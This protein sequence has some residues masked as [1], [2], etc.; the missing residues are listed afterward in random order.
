MGRS[1]T[2]VEVP[3]VV[4]GAAVAAGAAGLGLKHLRDRA[5]GNRG[6]SS[7][8]RLL[9]GEPVADGVKRVILGR[10]DDAVEQLSGGAPEPAEGVHEARKDLK[11]IRSALR[12]VRAELGDDVWRRENEHYR[13][14]GRALSGFRDAEVMVETLDTLGDRYGD[15]ARERFSGL[16]AELEQ[17][18]H[19]QRDDGL[20]QALAK[21]AGELESGRDRIEALPLKGDGWDLIGPGLH[22]SYRR[23]RKRLRAVE[24]SPTVENLHEWRKRVKDLWYQLR[25]IGEADPELIGAMAQHAHDLSDHLGDDHDLGLLSEEAEGRTAAFGEPADQR[26]LTELIRARRGELQFAATSLG[27]TIYDDKPK[28]FMKL[29]ESRWR[30]H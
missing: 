26:Y 5:D 30:S 12:L 19:R 15:A 23:G 8:Y 16:R 4:G 14:I 7:A 17:E 18:L 3:L 28:K 25:L 13:E 20:E 22:R 2:K 27:E 9:P 1:K 21:A 11:K 29:L 24:E 10:I 6:D